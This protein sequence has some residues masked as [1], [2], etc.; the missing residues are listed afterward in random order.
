MI[1][2]L[3]SY[4]RS[5]NSLA[6]LALKH[7][8][9][10]ETRTI[11]SDAPQEKVREIQHFLGEPVSEPE[12]QRIGYE[13]KPYFVKTHEPPIDDEHPALYVVRDGR[14]A[15]VSYAYYILQTE[16]SFPIR[17]DRKTFLRVLEELIM[18]D[19]H[20]GGWSGNVLAWNRRKAPTIAVRFEDMLRDP[21]QV[22]ARALA[23]IGPLRIV[24]NRGSFPSFEDLHRAFPWF[25]RH[26]RTG[27]WQSEMPEILQQLFWTRHSE[28]MAAF[29]YQAQ[30][31]ARSHASV[32]SEQHEK[33][34]QDSLLLIHNLRERMAMYQTAASERLQAMVE[35]DQLIL[36]LNAEAAGL[37]AQLEA[38]TAANEAARG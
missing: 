17:S 38:A 15:M 37:R 33:A 4:P 24:H 36:R 19:G 28:V 11:Y 5:G 34:L 32:S 30:S 35:K 6:S 20:F 31:S 16:Q 29:D 9:D 1:I 27:A 12:L 2:W 7:L 10:C 22:L 18:T 3:A 26:G 8:F 23:D 21:G 13:D 25:F 14:D